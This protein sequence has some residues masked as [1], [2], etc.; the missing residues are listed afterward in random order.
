MSDR[1]GIVNADEFPI[2]VYH[3]TWHEMSIYRS[4][5]DAMHSLDF[6]GK[7]LLELAAKVE[8]GGKVGYHNFN[9]VV[10]KTEHKPIALFST[11]IAR[12]YRVQ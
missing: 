11:N 12:R 10:G 4:A 8:A 3:K 2:Y 5:Y 9:H 6:R 1:N 7:E